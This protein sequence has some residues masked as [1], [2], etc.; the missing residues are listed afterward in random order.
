MASPAV[1]VTLLAP[2]LGRDASTTAVQ[3]STENAL[4]PWQSHFCKLL[5]QNQWNGTHLPVAEL[6]VGEG[7]DGVHES[8]EKLQT[9]LVCADP[10]HLRADRDT[11]SLMPAAMLG[12]TG[13]EADALL[14]TLNDF[15]AEDG[16]Q[17]WRSDACHWYM[18]GR[19][20]RTL[21]TFPPEFLSQ[22]NASAFLPEGEATGDWKRLMTELQMLL[23]AHPVNAQRQSS[24]LMPIN[25]LWFW[26]GAALNER[27]AVSTPDDSCNTFAESAGGGLSSAA[28]RGETLHVYADEPFAVALCR[29]LSLECRPLHEFDPVHHGAD[30]LLVD[31]R[32]E[33]AML[34]RDES[35]VEQA[36]QR[37]VNEWISCWHTRLQAGE[38]LTLDILDEDGMHGRLDQALLR[39]ARAASEAE[40]SGRGAASLQV[41]ASLRKRALALWRRVVGP[42]A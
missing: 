35:G 27:A 24:G 32:L 34:A 10:V 37:I 4:Q 39:Q 29:H 13:D 36:R 31:R 25:S 1:N 28:A 12:I 17:L 11:A 26:G 8:G 30:V 33:H 16:L 6:L 38:N 42:R 22:R 7:R 18:Q 20:G 21:H 3:W 14:L 41:L 40:R 15:L 5:A 9:A 23:H 19:D 2:G